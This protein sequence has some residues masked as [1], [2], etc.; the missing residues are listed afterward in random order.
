[1]VECLRRVF[2]FLMQLLALGFVLSIAVGM[3]LDVVPKSPTLNRETGQIVYRY[4]RHEDYTNHFYVT[5]FHAEAVKINSILFWVFLA[6][7]PVCSLVNWL[8]GNS[9]PQNTRE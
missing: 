8:S 1:M 2:N 7:M 4:E 9:D 6:G 5:P 3:V